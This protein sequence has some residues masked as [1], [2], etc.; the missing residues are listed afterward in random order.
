M[1]HVSAL[2]GALNYFDVSQFVLYDVHH[3]VD[4]F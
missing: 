4:I 1:A 3:F 2:H